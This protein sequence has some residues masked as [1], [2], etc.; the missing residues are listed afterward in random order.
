MTLRTLLVDPGAG[1]RIWAYPSVYDQYRERFAGHRRRMAAFRQS[2]PRLFVLLCVVTVDCAVGPFIAL[3]ARV[4]SRAPRL[5]VY[6]V[7]TGG[8]FVPLFWL[9]G[10]HRDPTK[11]FAWR[12]QSFI[13][14]ARCT[15]ILLGYALFLALVAAGAA[16]ANLALGI[17]L[18]VPAY[19]DGT[20]QALDIRQSNN[21]RRL[22]TGVMSGC[23]QVMAYTWVL[24]TALQLASRILKVG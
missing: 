13:V 8:L 12:S 14:C 19:L 22:V 18:N 21:P 3:L 4:A 20:V 6:N 24:I 10:C 16:Q 15:G 7:V 5:L 9:S 2:P 11:S 1:Q 17:L 23:G